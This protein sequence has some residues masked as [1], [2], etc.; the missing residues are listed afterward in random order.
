[1]PVTSLLAPRVTAR[2]SVRR[3]VVPVALGMVA[4]LLVAG[5]TA[6]AADRVRTATALAVDHQAARTTEQVLLRGRVRTPG[7]GA[8]GMTVRVQSRAPGGTFATVTTLRTGAQGRFAFL[9]RPYGARDYRAV[10]L[11]D[12]RRQASRSPVRQVAPRS[13]ARSLEQRSSLVAGRVGVREAG[14]HTQR[15][16]G[17]SVTWARHQRGILA[18][19]RRNT[20]VVSG[21]V[22]EEYL[23]RGGVGGRLGAPVAD[24]DCQGYENACLQRFQRGAIY[25]NPRA[26]RRVTTAFGPPARAAFLAVARSQRGYREPYYRGSKYSLW[27]NSSNAWCGFYLAWVSRASGNGDAFP[28]AGHFSQQVSTIRARGRTTS[29]PRVGHFAFIDYFGNGRPTHVGLVTK[30]RRDG[31]LVLLEGNVASNGGSGRP[32]GVFRIVRNRGSV[33]FYAR[34]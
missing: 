26:M 22:L 34:P 14:P 31:R 28:R 17:T 33:L 23:R 2:R 24:V 29:T 5:G 32:R 21:P 13:A 10:A 27:Q 4:S 15:R 12:S 25:V 9:H 7:G 18:Q 16:H 19:V 11:R 6:A 20:S 30:V 1:M 8:G 3:A